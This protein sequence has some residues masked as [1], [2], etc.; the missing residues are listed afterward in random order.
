[1]LRATVPEATADFDGDSGWTEY[2]VSR[3]PQTR[4]R[5]GAYPVAQAKRMQ[6]LPQ[7]QLRLGVLAP[8]RL[9]RLACCWARRP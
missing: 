3:S 2:D 4:E 8:V 7:S 6:L 9:H 1:M 5:A